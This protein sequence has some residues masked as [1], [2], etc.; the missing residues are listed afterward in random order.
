MLERLVVGGWFVGVT[1]M[2]AVA[3]TIAARRLAR[4][5]GIFADPHPN[6]QHRKP[7]P[8]LGGAAVAGAFTIG[9][10]GHLLAAD[11]IASLPELKGLV[12]SGLRNHLPGFE[13]GREVW[14]RLSVISAG[15]LLMFLVGLWDD[16][17]GL[18]VRRRIYPEFLIAL[19]YS[20]AILEAVDERRRRD[21][22]RFVVHN[23]RQ[24]R[25]AATTESIGFWTRIIDRSTLA[26]GVHEMRKMVQTGSQNAFRPPPKWGTVV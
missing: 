16:L 11:V 7:V 4:R 10:W 21:G 23:R 8:I 6:G 2:L 24:S 17:R 20:F 22:F 18:S 15:A 1:A 25:F 5:W 14:I 3:L 9:V 19:G 12:P 13:Q 26:C